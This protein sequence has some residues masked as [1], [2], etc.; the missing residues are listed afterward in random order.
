MEIIFDIH[1]NSKMMKKL[2]H[3]SSLIHNDIMFRLVSMRYIGTC[4]S[5]VLTKTS[6][7]KQVPDHYKQGSWKVVYQTAG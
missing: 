1:K 6:L 5:T 4:F 2:S 7:T 3:F